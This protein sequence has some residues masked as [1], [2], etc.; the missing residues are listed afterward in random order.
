MV[1]TTPASPLLTPEGVFVI[2]LR[3]DSAAATQHLVGLVEHVK[4]GSSEAFGSLDA[5]LRFIERHVSDDPTPAA[6]TDRDRRG[7]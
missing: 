7:E 2:H 4:S 5:L 1:C 6:R 3:S